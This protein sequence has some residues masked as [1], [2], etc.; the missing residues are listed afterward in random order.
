[1]TL[2]QMLCAALRGTMMMTIGV[3][4]DVL[5]KKSTNMLQVAAAADMSLRKQRCDEGKCLA[6]RRAPL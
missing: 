6:P 2:I 4:S 5:A 3:C 1:M